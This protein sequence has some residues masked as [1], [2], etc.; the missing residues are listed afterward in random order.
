MHTDATDNDQ[1]YPVAIPRAVIN[2]P[3]A[4]DFWHFELDAGAV[5]WH[6][7][8][9]KQRP[10]VSIAILAPIPMSVW[11]AVVVVLASAAHARE[12]PQVSFVKQE[13]FFDPVRPGD[14]YALTVRATHPNGIEKLNVWIN[15]SVYIHPDG[16]GETLVNLK[17]FPTGRPDEF[18]GE[19]VVPKMMPGKEDVPVPAGGYRLPS[20][21][22]WE[23]A[24]RAGT[25]TAYYWGEHADPGRC[26]FQ[27]S[28]IGHTVAVGSYEPN[29]WGLYDT[30][31][32]AAELT[33]PLW[34]SVGRYFIKGG[35]WCH[36]WWWL[37][38]GSYMATY[39]EGAES[40][41]SVTVGFR[42]CCDADQ[43]SA[44]KADL[45][46][47]TIVAT[48]ACATGVPQLK[49]D[50]GEVMNLGVVPG[51]EASLL[52][53]WDPVKG[54]SADRNVWIAWD[55]R[56]EG[57]GKTWQPCRQMPHTAVQLSDGTIMA[58][59]EYEG[60]PDADGAFKMLVSHDAWRSTE[61]TR[62]QLHLTQA[63]RGIG[64][65]QGLTQLGMKIVLMQGLIELPDGTLL[66]ACY[67]QFKGDMEHEDYCGGFMIEED[68]RK[69]RTILLESKDRGANWHLRATIANYPSFAREGC[70]E[71]DIVLLPGGGLFCAM[72]T[73]LSGYKDPRGI[74]DEHVLTAWSSSQG[75]HWS[76]VQKIQ[77]GDKLLTGI[78]PR[79]VVLDN[80][81]VGLLRSRPGS[82]VVFNP[83]GS[84]AVWT[85][86]VILVKESSDRP[87]TMNGLRQIGPDA[88]LV[89]F[90]DQDPGE[91]EYRF[92][93][94]LQTI[95]VTHES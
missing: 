16:K 29:P 59:H 57:G 87:G 90:R 91:T 93:M 43:A 45:D 33:G 54:P 56:T 61:T 26:N 58:I 35:S 23:Y 24:C 15:R 44:Q 83:D 41:Y 46:A 85:D 53:C 10:P 49:I 30:I 40:Q 37:D 76:D 13:T 71:P 92:D 39:S 79:I 14:A 47:P 31:G 94:K 7:M 64:V 5:C 89:A 38:A 52:T 60:R 1:R 73:G 67:A 17:L 74:Y 66:L 63:K 20:V 69:A 4:I 86:E 34:G 36:P 27:A 2:R 51:N 82:S 65:I 75:H 3:N 9:R 78:T 18:R 70:D 48:R 6:A 77:A 19:M 25:Q 95:T 8:A 80:G 28:R 88:M 81:V 55:R 62:C 21:V 12:L 11:V 50:L 22:E 32:N 68:F 84:G 72:R 42:L